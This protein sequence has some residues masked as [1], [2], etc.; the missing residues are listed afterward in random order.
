MRMLAF[1]SWPLPVQ[2]SLKN[3]RPK[4]KFIT[5]ICIEKFSSFTCHQLDLFKE[6]P[7]KFCWTSCVVAISV[8]VYFASCFGHVLRNKKVKYKIIKNRCFCVLCILY[9]QF[10]CFRRYFAPFFRL[11]SPGVEVVLYDMASSGFNWFFFIIILLN[12]YLRFTIVLF[13][14]LYVDFEDVNVDRTILS[15]QIQR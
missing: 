1:W 3:S 15:L 9:V 8:A 7:M 4:I 11:H 10:L 14:E 6:D 2:H 5:I 12:P 13:L